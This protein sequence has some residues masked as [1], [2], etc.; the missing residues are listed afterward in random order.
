[1]S[2]PLHSAN[3]ELSKPRR[4]VIDVET[5]SLADLRKVGAA[6]YAADPS[7]DVWCAAYAIDDQPVELWLPGEPVPAAIVKA[8]TDPDCLLI[9][10]SAGFETTIL[11]HILTP[12]HGWPEITL[13]RW[14]CTQAACLALALPASLGKVA[15]VLGLSHQKGDDRIMHQLARPRR[16]RGDEDPAA[17][18]YWYDDPEHLQ[19]LYDYCKQDVETER[20]LFNWLAAVSNGAAALAA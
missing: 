13:E 3:F 1:M 2:P 9:A 17:G 15:A 10:H 4:I 6:R 18:P 8:A 14:R 19:V 11:H 20:E 12:R 16:P 5:R 7:T